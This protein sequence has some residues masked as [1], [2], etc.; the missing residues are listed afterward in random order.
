M[1][2]LQKTNHVSKKNSGSF[3]AKSLA[4]NTCAYFSLFSE[5]IIINFAKWLYDIHTSGT[6]ALARVRDSSPG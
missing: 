3:A 2:G 5:K 6:N 4:K 1:H